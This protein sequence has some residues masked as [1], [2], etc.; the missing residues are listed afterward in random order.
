MNGT[1]PAAEKKDDKP[2]CMLSFD[3]RL[4][5]EVAKKQFEGGSPFPHS[6][7]PSGRSCV[8]YLGYA[9]LPQSI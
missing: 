1:L 8:A 3:K 4:E 9:H 7:P 6:T 2:A 5:N